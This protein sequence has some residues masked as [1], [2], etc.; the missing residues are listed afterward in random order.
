MHLG[1]SE[2]GF[3]T[4]C[5]IE[6]SEVAMRTFTHNNP[7][8]PTYCGDI[9]DFAKRCKDD[10]EFRS[11][12]GGVDVLHLSPPCQG[13]SKANRSGGA[14]DEENNSLSLLFPRLLTMTGARVGTFENVQ[15][16]WSQ[17]G[18]NHLIKILIDCIAAGYQVRVK[19]LRGE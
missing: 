3:D 18:I 13:F 19:V 10:E 2:E 15:G 12:V 6:M 1:F 14:N 16:M 17:K 9:R 5:A 8:V 11:W 4:A 7:G